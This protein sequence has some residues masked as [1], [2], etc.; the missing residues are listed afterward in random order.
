LTASNGTSG[1]EVVNYG[2]FAATL[3]TTGQ[4]IYPDGMIEKW[5]TATLPISGAATTSVAVVFAVAFPTAVWNIQVTPSRA[6]SSGGFNA[7][8]NAASATTAGFT[9]EGDSNSPSGLFSR[10][11]V[12]YWRAI[13]N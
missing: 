13:G 12:V 9:V 3:A 11:V 10:T 1:T 4:R 6:I 2:Q 5:G 8:C 7:I